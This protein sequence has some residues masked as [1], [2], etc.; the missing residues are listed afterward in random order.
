M[1]HEQGSHARE[2]RR[3]EGG[4]SARIYRDPRQRIDSVK[5]LPGEFYVTSRDVMLVTVLGAGV[6]VCL[7]DTATGVGSMMH[8]LAPAQHTVDGMGRDC[9]GFVRQ[10]IRHMLA[11]LSRSATR[12]NRLQARVYGGAEPDA[13]DM[14][15]CFAPDIG[16]HLAEVVE[17]C[18]KREEIPV[19]GKDVG[20]HQARKLW[21][22]PQNGRTRV[23][24]LDA[25]PNA[26]VLK[27]ELRVLCKLA[28]HRADPAAM[29]F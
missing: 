4:K 17:A 26:T 5:L 2:P 9:D 13:A 21:F 29:I 24:T 23:E 1:F 19:I 3:E 11:V 15:P 27:R 10:A 16:W 25:L 22:R 18:L 7:R 14:A 28:P 12:R 8:V 20:G 6:A